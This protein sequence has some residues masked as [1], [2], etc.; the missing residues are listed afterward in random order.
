ME[1]LGASIF[2]VAEK[3]LL[4]NWLYYIE[5]ELVSQKSVCTGTSLNSIVN[6]VLKHIPE[7]MINFQPLCLW[8]SSAGSIFHQHGNILAFNRTKDPML[9]SI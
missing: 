1:K 5:K 7:L 6:R 2:M 4:D 3:Q 8:Q 9:H